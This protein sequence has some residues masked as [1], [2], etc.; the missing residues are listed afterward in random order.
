MVMRDL[1]SVFLLVLAAGA[2]G[3]VIWGIKSLAPNNHP[4]FS[5]PPTVLFRMVGADGATFTALDT[6]RYDGVPA[7]VDAM[8]QLQD[9]RLL[10]WRRLPTGSQAV[11]IDT[12]NGD[13][14]AFGTG[15][16]LFGRE[17]R[18]AATNSAGEVWALDALNASAVR[19]DTADG[20]VAL[21]VPLTF[22]GMPWTGCPY[23][24]IAFSDSA[25]YL[26]GSHT[27]YL[28]DLL[29]G[30]VTTLYLDTQTDAGDVLYTCNGTPANPPPIN[31][32]LAY[33]PNPGTL[34]TF[35]TACEDDLFAYPL[36]G[37]SQR[38][39][40]L[41]HLIPEFNSGGGDLAGPPLPNPSTAVEDGSLSSVEMHLVHGRLLIRPA[42][43]GPGRLLVDVFDP[44]GKLV[45][46][47]EKALSPLVEFE[48][49]DA[50]GPLL[51]RVSLGNRHFF[52][53]VIRTQ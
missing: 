49:A 10:A 22:N 15:D 18:G 16:T 43:Q 48:L 47:A 42:Q 53:K 36:G 27:I 14:T 4:E 25:C 9:G 40:L 30:T 45:L 7:D 31:R 52:K 3:Q 46:H 6:L 26:T 13:L 51:I 35:D 12:L 2:N 5:A 21:E 37:L 23:C 50:H 17:L 29:T 20:S 44:L 24:D 8:C 1:I 11:L 39:E 19:M 34:I 32:G 41:D 33:L 38:Q 28:A